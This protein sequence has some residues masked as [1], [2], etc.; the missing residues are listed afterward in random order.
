MRTLPTTLFFISLFWQSAGAQ[1]LELHID[2]DYSIS[3]EAALSIESGVR[4]ALSE[5]GGQIAGYQID[6][7]ANDHRSNVRR[8]LRTMKNYLENDRALA[9]VGGLHSP[10][11]LVHQKFINQN[12]I[13]TLLPWSAAGPITRPALGDDNWIFRLSIDD[14]KTAP[15]LV[16]KGMEGGEC[17][18]LGLILIDTGWGRANQATLSATLNAR[19]S[20]PV[21]SQFFDSSIDA[22]NAH[23]FAKDFGDSGAD[24]AII[25]SDWDNGAKVMLGLHDHASNVRVFSHWGIMGGAFTQRVPNDIRADLDLR[26]LQT[27][28]LSREADGNDILSAALRAADENFDSLS[29]VPASTGFVHGY[30]L[31][32]IFIAAVRQASTTQDWNGNI[33]AKRLAVRNALEQLDSAVEGILKTYAPPFEPYTTENIDAHEALGYADLCMYQFDTDGKLVIIK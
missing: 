4:T 5:V 18:D 27:C 16:D 22:V 30:D 2:A 33:V 31:T 11:Y 12:G 28:G 29:D 25:L 14:F 20:T 19:G 9:L 8:S 1:T 32:R 26:V 10:P 7:V 23:V 13:L 15:F 3:V 6:I 17:T 21:F 24:C